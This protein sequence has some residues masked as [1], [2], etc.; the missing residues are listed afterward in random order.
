MNI[1]TPTANVWLKG[2]TISVTGTVTDASPTSVQVNGLDAGV[3]S[4]F[5]ISVPATDGVF[6]INVVARD[7]AGNVGTSAVTINVDSIAPKITI[8]DPATPLVTKNNT[9]H[10]AGTVKRRFRDGRFSQYRRCEFFHTGRDG[11][12]YEQQ[13]ND[14][15]DHT[16]HDRSDGRRRFAG[17]V[18]RRR[19]SSRRGQRNFQRRHRRENHRGRRCSNRERHCVAGVD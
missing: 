15:H 19:N 2:P 13:H 7:A 11:C 8:T 10:L 3:T 14:G 4:S 5:S 16:R 6:V 12:G 17:E 18:L 9:A 1:T